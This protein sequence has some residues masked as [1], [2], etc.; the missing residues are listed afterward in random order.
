MFVL[1]LIGWVIFRSE[2]TA[3]IGYIL[4]HVGWDVSE[5]GRPLVRTVLLAA[6]PLLAVQIHQ[7]RTR[8]LLAPARLP[9][10]QRIPLYALLLAGLVVL[11]VR[12]S[13]DFIYFQF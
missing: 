2:N 7:H 1:T 9:G 12:Q 5:A 4:T 3:Q 8:D 11:G 6:L 10:W 13:V